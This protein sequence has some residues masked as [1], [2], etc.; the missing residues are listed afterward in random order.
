MKLSG[1][2]PFCW[3]NDAIE[4]YLK[5]VGNLMK[6]TDKKILGNGM[7]QCS[8]VFDWCMDVKVP[9]L[10]ESL[11]GEG[12]CVVLVDIIS[13]GRSSSCGSS[14]VYGRGDEGSGNRGVGTRG[15][16]GGANFSGGNYNLQRGFRWESI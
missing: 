2:H 11:L 7:I 15:N 12:V 16:R 5:G 3:T 10:F 14:G 6:V 9:D 4:Y 13:G 8:L 1:P